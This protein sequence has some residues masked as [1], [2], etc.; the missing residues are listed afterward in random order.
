MLVN[1]KAITINTTMREASSVGAT[2]ILCMRQES[3]VNVISL[4]GNINIQIFHSATDTGPI[5]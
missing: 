3:S 4:L 5:S 2:K 1:G